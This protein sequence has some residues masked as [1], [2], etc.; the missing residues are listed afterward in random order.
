MVEKDIIYSSSV[1]YDG[2]FSFSDFYEFC[3]NWVMSEVE[4]DVFNEKSYSEKI[5][6][7]KK[8]VEL[9][10]EFEKKLTDY[11]KYQ[12]KVKMKATIKR[13]VEIEENGR[14]IQTNKGDIKIGVKGA[15]IQDYEK[16]F[17]GTAFLKMWRSIYEK[18][19][20]QSRVAEFEG[21]TIGDSEEFLQQ[22][23]AFLDL[24]TKK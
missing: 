6:G 4:P 13:E 3:H 8:V 17:E 7:N 14:K 18:W 12:I 16:Q 2:I 21:K 1:K 24:E 10:W 23:R 5:D 11:F 22:A 20:M 19:I 9:E 15:L